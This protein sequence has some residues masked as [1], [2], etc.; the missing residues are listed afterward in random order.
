M[1]LFCSYWATVIAFVCSRKFIQ[2]FFICTCF[3]ARCSSHYG[4]FSTVQSIFRKHC[5]SFPLFFVFSCLVCAV[6]CTSGV[7]LR[8]RRICPT[9]WWRQIK[10]VVCPQSLPELGL[11]KIS[12]R[13]RRSC[14]SLS[15]PQKEKSF[16]LNE[17]REREGKATFLSFGKAEY[18]GLLAW[19]DTF[20]PGASK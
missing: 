18:L 1:F 19:N 9:S 11:V 14:Q 4:H 17:Q 7:Y 8:E 3:N 5:L 20:S 6:L 2:L 10:P 16:L 15:C 13:R 12:A